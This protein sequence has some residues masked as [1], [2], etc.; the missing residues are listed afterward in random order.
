MMTPTIIDER[1]FNRLPQVWLISLSPDQQVSR[2]CTWCI[3]LLLKWHG[4][5]FFFVLKYDWPIEEFRGHTYTRSWRGRSKDKRNHRLG[6]IQRIAC[7]WGL[8]KKWTRVV[9]FLHPRVWS[10]NHSLYVIAEVSQIYTWPTWPTRQRG[11]EAWYAQSIDILDPF[12]LDM[13]ACEWVSKP[14]SWFYC[15]F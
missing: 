12:R 7:P 3:L 13:E 14:S 9:G 6:P 2:I 11:E 5:C 1:T 15:L 4:S 8:L 10:A